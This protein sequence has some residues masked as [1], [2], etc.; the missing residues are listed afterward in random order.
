[1]LFAFNVAPPPMRSAETSSD[2][3]SA[4]PHLQWNQKLRLFQRRIPSA[5]ASKPASIPRAN[6]NPL[7][8]TEREGFGFRCI[9][10]GEGA[11]TLT[12]TSGGIEAL[13]RKRRL[14][15]GQC[16]MQQQRLGRLIS[17]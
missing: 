15:A 5:V 12:E 1:M 14:P 8:W 2:A 7:N 17:A 16:W 11:F 13:P 10:T 9:M 4:Q 3:S 6:S